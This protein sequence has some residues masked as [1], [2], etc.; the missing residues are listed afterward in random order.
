[1]KIS[2]GCLTSNRKLP[3]ETLFFGTAVLVAIVCPLNEKPPDR[4]KPAETY[5]ILM[6]ETGE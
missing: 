2:S 1:V 5:P 3:P 4:G 6:R